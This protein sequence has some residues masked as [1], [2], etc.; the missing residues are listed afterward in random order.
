MTITVTEQ[1]NRYKQLK[2]AGRLSARVNQ[3]SCSH[4]LEPGR[5]IKSPTWP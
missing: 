4:I 5:L 1:I 2:S 3:H